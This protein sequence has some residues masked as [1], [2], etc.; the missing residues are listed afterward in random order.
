M[1]VINKKLMSLSL[2]TNGR[3]YYEMK[4]QFNQKMDVSIDCIQL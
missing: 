2:L 3:P 1:G 4:A